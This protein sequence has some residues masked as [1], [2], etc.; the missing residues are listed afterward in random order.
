MFSF[1]KIFTFK[2]GREKI[3]SFCVFDVLERQIQSNKIVKEINEGI[4][5]NSTAF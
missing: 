2:R 3:A 4:Q 5:V 1:T